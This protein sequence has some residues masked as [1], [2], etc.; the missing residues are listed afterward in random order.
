MATINTKDHLEHVDNRLMS[1]LESQSLKNSQE[2]ADAQKIEKYLKIFKDHSNSDPL[3]NNLR[4]RMLTTRGGRSV[5]NIFH[6]SG[7]RG[8]YVF[9][10]EIASLIQAL[11]D[12]VLGGGIQSTNKKN[13]VYYKDDDGKKHWK[14]VIQLSYDIMTGSTGAIPKKNTLA[15]GIEQDILQS[16]YQ[17][18]QNVNGQTINTNNFDEYF[19]LV[20]E[21][22]FGKPDIYSKGV[23]S[24]NVYWDT[25]TAFGELLA[26]FNKYN[27]SLKSYSSAGSMWDKITLG[28][29]DPYKAYYSILTE[30]GYGAKYIYDSYFRARNCYRSISIDSSHG[31]HDVSLHMGHIQ[32]IYELTG[33]GMQYLNGKEAQAEMFIL[34][35]SNTGNIFVR[36]SSSMIK[37]FLKNYGSTYGLKKNLKDPFGSYKTS[38]KGSSFGVKSTY[39]KKR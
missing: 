10:E 6:T 19:G 1:W 9:E 5:K 23:I 38:I 8:G 7:T 27:F 11:A 32:S 4:Q 37:D 28:E 18:V 2:L 30:L 15:V 20:S 29:T 31:G 34:N 36:S 21:P 13:R 17:N 33:L 24:A 16:I 39:I 25:T 22:K 26:L 35:D 3:W 14:N 12:I